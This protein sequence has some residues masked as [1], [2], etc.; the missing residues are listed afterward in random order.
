MGVFK[1]LENWKILDLRVVKNQNM[2]WQFN[3]H[4]TRMS[5][6]LSKLL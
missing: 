5:T 3:V 4:I 1:S 2:M 6:R